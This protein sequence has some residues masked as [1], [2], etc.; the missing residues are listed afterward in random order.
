MDLIGFVFLRM[1][2]V[3]VMF[4]LS[5]K[6]VFYASFNQHTEKK[7]KVKTFMNSSKMK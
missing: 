1:G 6:I 7:N 3:G 5:V 2:S 4:F